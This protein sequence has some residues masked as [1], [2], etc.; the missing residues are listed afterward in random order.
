MVT[1]QNLPSRL[2]VIYSEKQFLA[3]FKSSFLFK[4]IDLV[5]GCRGEVYGTIGKIVNFWSVKNLNDDIVHFV[6][7]ITQR[8]VVCD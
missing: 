8:N 4:Y 7:A 3:V 2:H 5:T 1:G 6:R